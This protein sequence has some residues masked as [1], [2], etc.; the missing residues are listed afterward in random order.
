MDLLA[1]DFSTDLEKEDK[2][3]PIELIAISLAV[4]VLVASIINGGV[5]YLTRRRRR[6]SMFLKLKTWTQ[7]MQSLNTNK[8]SLLQ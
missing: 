2:K 4:G 6:G 5:V 7:R 8:I 1:V 3:L